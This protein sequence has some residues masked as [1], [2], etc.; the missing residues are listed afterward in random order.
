MVRKIQGTA[1]SSTSRAT[2]KFSCTI[3]KVK[4][5]IKPSNQVLIQRMN[6]GFKRSNKDTSTSYIYSHSSSSFSTCDDDDHD[7]DDDDQYF[8]PR[9]S[10]NHKDFENTYVP[11]IVKRNNASKVADR[12]CDICMDTKT[13]SEMFRN[14]KVCGHMFCFD[15]IRGHVVAKIQENIT[16]VRC[17]DPNCKGVIGPEACRLI[18]PREVA[19]VVEALCSWTSSR[20]PT[21]SQ[22]VC[23]IIRHGTDA[24]T[25]TFMSRKSVGVTAFN[26]GV[27]MLLIMTTEV[28]GSILTPCKARGP[29]LPPVGVEDGIETDNPWKTEDAFLCVFSS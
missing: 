18:V 3:S 5:K 26:A 16:K 12:F 6:I 8:T 2:K 17:P 23:A 4:C 11:P 13:E 27:D 9:S 10:T 25:A 24:Q 21:L 14:T 28:K 7:H 29:F 20:M 1:V 19:V 15:C 22:I